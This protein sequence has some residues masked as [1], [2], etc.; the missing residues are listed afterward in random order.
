MGA[1]Q[2][3]SVCIP[4][5]EGDWQAESQSFPSREEV[6]K[7]RDLEL[8]SFRDLS[9]VRKRAEYGFGSTVSN[10]ELSEFFGTH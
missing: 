6:L 5:C 4:R 1:N 10:T 3:T 2:S 8:L 9:Q 7:T